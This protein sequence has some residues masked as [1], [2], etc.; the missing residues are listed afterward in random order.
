M[1][2]SWPKPKLLT[3]AVASSLMHDMCELALM[4]SVALITETDV[5]YI[6]TERT[7][8]PE[9][10]RVIGFVR[11]IIRYNVDNSQIVINNK[12]LQL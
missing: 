5:G 1:A 10:N 2:H 6:P 7:D 9:N 8:A 4:M 11:N 12:Y 3:A